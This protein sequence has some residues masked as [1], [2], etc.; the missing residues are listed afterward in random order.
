MDPY[1]IP[2][3]IRARIRSVTPDATGGERKRDEM[4]YRELSR[5]IGLE[6]SAI[7]KFMRGAVR[8]SLPSLERLCAVLDLQ[9]VPGEMLPRE[10]SISPVYRKQNTVLNHKLREMDDARLAQG[11]SESIADGGGRP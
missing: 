10:K 6:Q 7:S 11:T 1:N 4:S 2:E 5:L 8:L 9:L 3:I